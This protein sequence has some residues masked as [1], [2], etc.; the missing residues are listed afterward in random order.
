MVRKIQSGK[1]TE[2]LKQFCLWLVFDAWTKIPPRIL[3]GNT[4]KAGGFDD[5]VAFRHSSNDSAIGT[6]QGQHCMANFR[7]T[8][9]G[10]VDETVRFDW[11]EM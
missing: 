4:V 8:Q 9:N 2:N 5:C 11:R 3:S 6:F 7:A 10:T 1:I